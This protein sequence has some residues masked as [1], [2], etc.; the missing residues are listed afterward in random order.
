MIQWGLALEDKVV[1]TSINAVHLRNKKKKKNT[2]EYLK[3]CRKSIWN[4]LTNANNILS[5]LEIEENFLTLINDVY[6][7]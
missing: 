1:R 2:H 7:T 6:I 3:K 5:K 4:Y